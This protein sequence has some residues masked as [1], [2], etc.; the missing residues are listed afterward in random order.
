MTP[1]YGVADP[2]AGMLGVDDTAAASVEP[3]NGIWGGS[4][5]RRRLVTLSRS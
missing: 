3:P 4:D 2:A 5:C 1:P